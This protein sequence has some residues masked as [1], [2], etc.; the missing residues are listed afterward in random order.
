MNGTSNYVRVNI[1]L[2][3]DLVKELKEKVPYRGV[4]RFLSEA[5]IEKMEKE[6]RDRAFKELMKA[7]PAFTFLKGKNTAVNWV[8]KL[9]GADE[10]RLKRVWKGRI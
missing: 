1:S 3:S 10:K 5:A 2:P 9:R 4:S 8:R 7:P 6:K